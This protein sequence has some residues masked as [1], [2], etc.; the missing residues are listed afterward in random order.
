MF[1][2]ETDKLVEGKGKRIMDF[3]IGQILWVL[4]ISITLFWFF[5]YFQIAQ[6]FIQKKLDQRE[7]EVEFQELPEIPLPKL[8]DHYQESKLIREAAEDSQQRA[9]EIIKTQKKS[10]PIQRP[11]SPRRVHELLRKFE[12]QCSNVSNMKMLV[13]LLT[14]T[15]SEICDSPTIFLG[16]SESKKILNLQALS[17]FK[18]RQVPAPQSLQ[19]P[20]DSATLGR[21]HSHAQS[22][23]IASLS[24][25]PALESEILREFGV[26]HF[27]AW[28]LTSTQ[29]IPY[30]KYI[31]S[32]QNS[33]FFPSPRESGTFKL[34]GVLVV[35]EA[36]V[37]SALNRRPMV[38]MLKTTRVEYDK[39]LL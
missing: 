19:C 12:H 16:F 15:S 18:K 11:I 37:Q 36:G 39:R 9:Q 27:E 6:Q 33:P 24:H 21:I 30:Q 3:E 32:P 23:K 29:P 1:S 10:P 22:G 13:D 14:Y 26:A 34:L 20:M 4:G 7:R 38:Q 2:D 5:G 25:Y 17:G 8:T 28:A 31:Q 35:L